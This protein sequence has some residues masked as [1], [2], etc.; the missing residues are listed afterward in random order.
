MPFEYD[1][2]PGLKEKI[3]KLQKKDRQLADMLY[4]KIRQIVN[5]EE[6]SIEHFKN[7]KYGLSDK[8]RVHIDKSF[9]LT[10]KFDKNLKKVY[11]IDFGH[12]G[13]IYG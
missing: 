6:N 4:K 1:I 11:F 8:K 13:R 5:L 7:L 3:L 9:V 10:F 12:H 2:L